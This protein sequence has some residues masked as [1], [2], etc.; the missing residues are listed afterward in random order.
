MTTL[1]LG[2][3]TSLLLSYMLLYIYYKHCHPWKAEGVSL[4]FEPNDKEV[5]RPQPTNYLPGKD[6]NLHCC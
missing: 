4:G 5:W 2:M 6:Q 1:T 3:L